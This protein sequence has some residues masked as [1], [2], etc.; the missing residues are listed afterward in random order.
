MSGL[1][2]AAVYSL[3]SYSLGYCGPQ[4]AKS[5]KALIDYTTGKNVSEK[6]VRGIFEKFEAAYKY[7]QL[8]AKKNNITDPL[9]EKVVKAFWVGNSLLG[10]VDEKDLKNLILTGFTQPG[11]L[12]EEVASQRADQV[13]K[14]AVPHHSFHVL[15][16]GAVTGRIKLQGEMLDLCRIGWGRI[17]EVKRKKLKVKYKPL[18]V[19]KTYGFGKEVEKEIEWNPKI[20]PDVKV[21]DIASFHWAQVCE[22]LTPQEVINLENYTQNTIDLVNL[23]ND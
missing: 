5:R 14:G 20:A 8:I 7:Y 22:V 6:A 19:G 4:D 3:P 15:I 13:P 1:K 23:K 21:G 16:L 9:D 2:T 11:L 12:T 18:L 10:K 17:L